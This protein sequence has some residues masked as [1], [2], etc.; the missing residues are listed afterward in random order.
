M[1]TKNI[2]LLAICLIFLCCFIGVASAADDISADAQNAAADDAV[3]VDTV[4]EDISDSAIADETPVEAVEDVTTEPVVP[5]DASTEEINDEIQTDGIG[6]ESEIEDSEPTKANIIQVSNW[7]DLK[8]ECSSESTKY[9][10]LSGDY[11][12]ATS[13]I[14][15]ANSA[16]IYGNSHTYITG[17][18]SNIIPFVSS[19]DLSITFQDVIFK[20][21]DASVLIKFATTGT[22]KFINCRF[23]NIHTHA[24][25]SSVIW[26][27][28][29]YM[30]I[31][32]CNFTNC[33]DGFGAVTNYATTGTVQM[34]V[35]NC[36]FENN[37][38]RLEPGAI[39]N[40]GNLTVTGS[41]FIHNVATWWAGAIHT[42]TFAN[43]T[44]SDS[45]FTDNV[46]GW[47]GGALFS[48]GKLIVNNSKFIGNNCTTD[49]GGGAICGYSYQGSIYNITVDSCNFTNNANL[50]SNGRGG[51]IGVQNIGNLT[52][53]NSIFINND[54]TNGTAIS[55]KCINV[56]Y[57][58]N[59]TNCSCPN[60]PNCTNCSHNVS[61]GDPSCDIHNNTFINHT[62]SGDTVV[63]SGND[64]VFYDNYFYNCTQSVRYNESGNHYGLSKGDLDYVP[65]TCVVPKLSATRLEGEEVVYVDISDIVVDPNDQE[66]YEDAIDQIARRYKKACRSV[67][68]GGIIYLYNGKYFGANSAE[69]MINFTVIGMEK[70]NVIFIHGLR[71][72]LKI[73]STY[74]Q[75]FTQNFKNMTFLDSIF[76]MDN[77][78]TFEDC[79]FINSTIN[80]NSEISQEPP[81]NLVDVESS[82]SYNFTNCIF[83]DCAL[84]DSLINIYK[85]GQINF[86]NCTFENIAGNSL[87]KN[88]L[89]WTFEDAINFYDCTFTNVA[90]KGIVDVPTGT[91]PVERYRIEGCTGVPSV[92]V[93]TEGDSDF[94][95]TTQSRTE[96]VMVAEIDAD[97][98]LFINL[99]DASGNAMAEEEVLISI[100]GADAT[101]YAIGTDGTL[102][103]ALTN[104]TDVTGKLDITVTFEE[105]DD[106]K[107]S[108]GSLSTV[109]VINNVT[110]EV[111]V[112]VPVYITVN[113]TATSITAS[114]LTATAK[115]AKTLSVTLK[116]ADGKV[117]ANK[118]V[119]VTVNG[120]TSTVTT[121]KNGVAKVNV[122]YA[123]AGT[124][125]YTLS[126]LGDNDYKASMK[127]VKVTVN[128]QATK[129][130]FAKKTFK[131]KAT[132]KLTFTL[133]DAKGKA[134]KGK[135]IT[136]TVNKKTYTAKT[137]AKGIATVKVKLTKKGKYTAVAKFAGDTTYK[138]I[139]KKAAITV[140]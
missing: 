127:A 114:D 81:E 38:G 102:S 44:I 123:K 110:V 7:A 30:N 27:D 96:T 103:I 70:E 3:S 129:A 48:Y 83:K 14:T 92:G 90:V 128:K 52:V 74:H 56:T 84:D 97:G 139:S 87:V 46:A 115:V 138:A 2:K 13:Q 28:K 26:N 21:M 137:N 25:K 18:N 119:K 77:D 120:K 61:T 122:N 11:I 124:Y 126:F 108:T 118:A 113:Q 99:T 40:C 86:K 78:L 24:Y 109:L 105:N 31:S 116:D 117:L 88:N 76:K 131:V 51:A 89:G 134:I 140:K 33:N 130:T 79:I 60:C 17:G 41:T 63:I 101:P 69:E 22:N 12:T 35:E 106:Y 64:Y 36:R 98:N 8:D 73:G 121:D 112:E 5:D 43:T 111:P 55:A 75:H 6:K 94:V 50:N 23:D 100:N 49:T 47:N 136:F 80:A 15:F 65:Q 91:T 19:G 72:T 34:N 125:Y 107:G 82:F 53:F 67:N 54:A 95:N 59:C 104:L 42:H 39:N 16:T 85:Y 71:T 62:G 10:S 58:N 135:K 68:D 93:V 20:D 132:K 9:I 29:G 32:G 45:T 66:A 57:C 37:S 133:K 1:R 4:S